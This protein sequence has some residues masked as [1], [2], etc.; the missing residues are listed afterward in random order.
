MSTQVAL[1]T[2]TNT[3]KY[4]NL[5]RSRYAQI[6]KWISRIRERYAKN[7]NAYAQ[8]CTRTHM[9]MHEYV[10]QYTHIRTHTHSIHLH[11]MRVQVLGYGTLQ[12]CHPALALLSDCRT[13]LGLSD[14]RLHCRIAVGMCRM[15][16]RHWKTV[17]E[18]VDVDLLSELL[19]DTV[20][21]CRTVGLLVVG[22]F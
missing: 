15:H 20:G 1:N 5:I 2:Q 7:A 9:H 13:Y 6:R 14:A 17:E 21:H 12:R 11:K 18:R 16:G 22:L 8:I 3:H 19:S 4:A 10:N